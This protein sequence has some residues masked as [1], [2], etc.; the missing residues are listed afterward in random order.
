M[1]SKKKAMRIDTQTTSV[2]KAQ[3]QLLDRTSIHDPAIHDAEHHPDRVNT[4]RPRDGTIAR[5]HDRQPGAVPRD[6]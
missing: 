6:C 5:P 1:A 2:P 3:I 4:P